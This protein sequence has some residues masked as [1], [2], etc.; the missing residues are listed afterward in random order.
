MEKEK[1]DIDDTKQTQDS[2]KNQYTTDR[3][4]KLRRKV[5]KILKHWINIET[6]DQY[7]LTPLHFATYRANFEIVQILVKYGAEVYAKS[8][9]GLSMVHMAV[10]ADNTQSCKADN[11]HLLTYFKEKGVSINDPDN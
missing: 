4:K 3:R 10:K 5:M 2:S 11:I 9:M 1:I 6:K 7:G 8:K